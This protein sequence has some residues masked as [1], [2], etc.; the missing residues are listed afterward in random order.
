[1]KSSFQTSRLKHR[2]SSVKTSGCHYGED[3]GGRDEGWQAAC[4]WKC[5]GEEQL[6]KEMGIFM[7]AL[8]G[9]E[10]DLH[11]WRA[12]KRLWSVCG[13]VVGPGMWKAGGR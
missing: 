11:R 5:S 10:A 4:P 9:R 8:W 6:A 1:M 3:A 7:E 13:H 2:T 12:I